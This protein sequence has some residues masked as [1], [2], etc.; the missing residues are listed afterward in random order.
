MLSAQPL[1]KCSPKSAHPTEKCSPKSAHPS[2]KCSPKSAHPSEKF[3]PKIAHNSKV[4]TLIC[5]P[6]RKVLLQKCSPL[7]SQEVSTSSHCARWGLKKIRKTGGG[8]QHVLLILWKIRYR[9]CKYRTK[10]EK[11]KNVFWIWVGDTG[12]GLYKGEY[13][14][15]WKNMCV[16]GIYI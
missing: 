3:S 15:M 14:D 6:L 5:L 1:D 13:T 4:F 8:L 11:S 16:V 12:L 7:A 2:S 9:I 10:K